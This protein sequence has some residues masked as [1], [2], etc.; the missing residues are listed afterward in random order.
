MY[1]TSPSAPHFPASDNPCTIRIMSEGKP[2]IGHQ[3]APYARAGQ[4]VELLLWVIAAVFLFASPVLDRTLVREPIAFLVPGVSLVFIMYAYYVSWRL[5]TRGGQR[6]FKDVADGLLLIA[7]FTLAFLFSTPFFVVIFLP[8]AAVTLTLDL[9]EPLAVM[10]LIAL[11]VMADIILGPAYYATLGLSFSTTQLAIL[12]FL[13]LFCRYLAHELQAQNDAHAAATAHL[14][15]LQHEL[16]THEL[17][18]ESQQE[19]FSNTTHHLLAPLATI[20]HLVRASYETKPSH[21]QRLL[22]EE[23]DEQQR[24]V[25]KMVSELASEERLLRDEGDRR[26]INVVELTHDVVDELKPLATANASTIVVKASKK[27]LMAFI[28][29]GALRVILWYLLENSLL[30]SAK[31]GRVSL[32]IQPNERSAEIAITDTGFGI[33][34]EDAPRIFDRFYRGGQARTVNPSGLGL[35][36]TTARQLARQQD[37]DVRLTA[38]TARGSTFTITLPL[39][40][41]S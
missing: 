33:D 12:F 38:S 26:L 27:S 6:L 1:A 4:A 39:H 22:L 11:F 5:H 25:R 23:I 9:L 15:R 36:L 30:Y 37:G 3:P 18:Q 21:D 2:Q 32:T 35:G 8:I 10:L 40:R 34:E 24:R 13:A 28:D 16:E 14:H 17:T 31:K 29:P 41:G 19:I 20:A 7:I